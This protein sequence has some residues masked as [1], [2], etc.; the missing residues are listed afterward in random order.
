MLPQGIQL[1]KQNF[2]HGL[3]SQMAESNSMYTSQGVSRKTNK[4][5]STSVDKG[6]KFIR[7]FKNALDCILHGATHIDF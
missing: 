5:L 7:K 2:N 4:V 3:I 6:K 1:Q